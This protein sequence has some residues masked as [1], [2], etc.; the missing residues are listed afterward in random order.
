MYY[1]VK[2]L[3]TTSI[4]RSY[5]AAVT[6]MTSQQF[7]PID[8]EIA[9]QAAKNIFDGR[10]CYLV[11]GAQAAGKDVVGAA[12]A[13][14]QDK[15]VQ[16][17]M[18]DQIRVETETLLDIVR[19]SDT[20]TQAAEAAK[21]ELVLE[22]V[23]A[24]HMVSS[25]WER[26]RKDPEF[27]AWTRDDTMRGLLQYF[28]S[29]GRNNLQPGYWTQACYF[30][31]ANN[32]ANNIGVYMADGRYPTEVNMG[33]TVGVHATRLFVPEDIRIERIRRRDGFTPNLETLRH[34]GE[35]ALDEHWTTFDMVIDNSEEVDDVINVVEAIE[36]NAEHMLDRLQ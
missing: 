12:L 13:E 36:A 14:R 18:S 17:R 26:A 31:L 30:A 19:G 3:E 15:M 28:G 16:V 25:V 32:V 23:H 35:I 5:E 2:I 11:S 21:V 4:Q 20:Q 33:T 27:S 7:F 22:D 24:L 8:E 29:D 9:Q 6:A 34:S 10:S 1:T